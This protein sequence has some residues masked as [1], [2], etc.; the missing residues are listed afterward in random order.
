MKEYP[1]KTWISPRIKIR[2]S[3]IDGREMFA[4]API[5]AGEKV[6]VFGGVYT[7]DEG[8]RKAQID[9]KKLVMHWDDDLY[10]VEERG[11]D[12]SYFINHSCDPNIWMQDAFTLIARRAIQKGEELTADYA[13]WEADANF[14]TKWECHCNSPLCRK[15]VTGNDWRIKELQERYN[16]HFSPLLNK[17]IKKLM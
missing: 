2:S 14:V 9:K 3:T 1:S 11:D 16:G 6:V 4:T 5:K 13:L 10:S 7:D 17:R 15:R 12:D 8:A